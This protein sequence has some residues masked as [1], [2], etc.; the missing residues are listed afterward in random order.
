MSE[1][2]GKTFKDADG[3][4]WEVVGVRPFA[5][6]AQAQAFADELNAAI[7]CKSCDPAAD[8]VDSTTRN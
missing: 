3:R 4:D 6:R 2:K 1:V 8:A 5:D 7:G